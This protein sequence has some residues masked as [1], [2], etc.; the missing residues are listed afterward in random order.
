M[1]SAVELLIQP[2]DIY[3]FNQ[4]RV[5]QLRSA[6]PEI[7]RAYLDEQILYG[8]FKRFQEGFGVE[9]DPEHEND[10]GNDGDEFPAS[11]VGQVFIFRIIQLLEHDTLEHP[12][13]VAGGED[14]A[15]GRHGGPHSVVL[16]YTQ[17]DEKFPDESVRGRESDRRQGPGFLLKITSPQN[18]SC[19]EHDLA[20]SSPRS[21]ANFRH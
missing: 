20:G 4:F 8:S 3:L 18:P 19:F 6:R 12:Q 7:L 16:E 14:N 21:V 9:T 1:F 11:H 2:C 5:F 17:Q 15:A 10:N 13:D